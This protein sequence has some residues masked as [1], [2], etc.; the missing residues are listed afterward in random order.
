MVEAEG[1]SRGLL[2]DK[3]RWLKEQ[4]ALMNFY[5]TNIVSSK[6][7][8]PPHVLEAF[9]PILPMVISLDILK[10]KLLPTAEKM[11]LR[12]PEVALDSK[13]NPKPY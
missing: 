7:A 9:N 6:V 8:V 5:A 11:L 1:V 13:Q 3:A 12:S 2:D 10:D 4:D